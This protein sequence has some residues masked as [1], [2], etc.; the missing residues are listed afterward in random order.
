M[1]TS[2]VP[3]DGDYR[4]WICLA[5]PDE[6]PP[7]GNDP[8]W[9][10]PCK[11]NLIAHQCCLL[12]WAADVSANQRNRPGVTKLPKCPQCKATIYVTK[13]HSRFL[14]LR[15]TIEA[16]NTNGMQL[17]FVSSVSGSL[18]TAVYTTLYAMGAS[19]IR[20]MCPT[21]MALDLLGLTVT[22]RRVA[23]KR[24]SLRRMLLIPSV[25]VLLLISPSRSRLIDAISVVLPFTLADREHLP[26]KFQGARF[27]MAILPWLRLGYR[28]LYDRLMDPVIQDCAAKVRPMFYQSGATE[29]PNGGLNI[30]VFVDRE[31]DQ[32]D[33]RG[34]QGQGGGGAGQPLGM[35]QVLAAA[36]AG[37]GAVQEE[38][39]HEDDP[40]AAVEVVRNPLINRMVLTIV[41]WITNVVDPPEPAPLIDDMNGDQGQQHGQEGRGGPGASS[42]SSSTPRRRPHT[43]DWVI[44]R[45]TFTLR[46]GHQLLLPL[47]SGMMGSLLSTIPFVRKRIP[48][49]FHRNMFGGMLVVV[50]R[51][52]INVISA[53]LRARQ[54]TSRTVLQHYEI[55][56][57]RRRRNRP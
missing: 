29:A 4:C 51:D 39:D 32:P 56:R 44:S 8:E 49:R 14:K 18:F 21:D 28:F 16:L 53:L 17:L 31:P 22:G 3:A 15:E 24:I 26:W 23:V 37:G 38:D 42:S 10:R 55:P 6:P 27:T 48:S 40:H 54:E 35:D 5:G 50:L 46:I 47:L 25:P 19:S 34:Q 12:E 9:R 30:Q 57:R 33:Q 13:K 7:Q 2:V 52:L 41:E 45:R 36:A 11:C 1:D 20:L 43:A